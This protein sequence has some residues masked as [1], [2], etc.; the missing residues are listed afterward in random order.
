LV[1][2]E[3]RKSETRYAF[4]EKAD[5]DYCGFFERGGNM[6][7]GFI[8][9]AVGFT[10]A[11]LLAACQE[12]PI[13][14]PSSQLPQSPSSPSQLPVN[15]SPQVAEGEQL[16]NSIRCGDCH[17]ATDTPIAP[18]LVGLYNSTSTVTVPS[19]ADPTAKINVKADA[20]YIRE[21]IVDPQAKIVD[22]Y[23]SPSIMPNFVQ[24]ENLTDEQVS[25]LVAYVETL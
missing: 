12:G 9:W 18:S 14:P 24:E 20:D 15:A 13:G 4:L 22:G 10:C 21:S 16:F 8:L 11:A 23:P 17:K 2:I 25:A 6:G 5:Y 1:L 7:N 19:S 3:H